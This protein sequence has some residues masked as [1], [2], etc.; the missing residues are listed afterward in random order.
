MLVAHESPLALLD[1]SR[2][3][4]DYDYCLVHL[5]PIYK[6]YL[7]YFKK[8]K[9]MGRRILLD[10][11]LFEL[12]EAFEPSEFAKWINVLKPYEYVAPDVFSDSSATIDS[13]KRWQD[14]Y[15]PTVEGK[16]IGVVQGKTYQEM[17]K[18]YSFMALN[19]DKIAINFISSYFAARGHALEPGATQ[20]HVLMDG[21]QNFI[22]DLMFDGVWCYNKPHHLLGCTLPQEF[23]FYEGV[24]E[25]ES[26]DTSNPVVA[27][28]YDIKYSD[29]GLDDKL[30]HKLAELMES[31]VTDEHW[32]N[33]EYNI[34][35]FRKINRIKETSCQE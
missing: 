22:R 5:L 13:F 8:S 10:N 32:N 25:I 7:D 27:G 14:T 16:V 29:H 19:A 33:I 18:C 35:M 9:E 17:I 1:K 12:G 3:Y 2:S 28:M 31:P 34:K 23:A 15:M 4:N 20:W 24:D 11:S 21:R 26:I 30:I 6:Q